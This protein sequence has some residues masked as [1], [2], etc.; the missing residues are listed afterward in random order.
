[1]IAGTEKPLYRFDHGVLADADV[2]LDSQA[3]VVGGRRVSL[4][5]T[6]PYPDMGSAAQSG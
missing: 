4:D 2:E 3:I 1:M 6:S 5:L